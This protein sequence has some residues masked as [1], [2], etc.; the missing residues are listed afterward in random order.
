M[1]KHFLVFILSILAFV[2]SAQNNAY[3]F[4]GTTHGLSARTHSL[5]G[6]NIGVMYDFNLTKSFYLQ[7]GFSLNQ[8]ITDSNWE[9]TKMVF[10]SNIY[11]DKGTITKDNYIVI[12]ASI[13][14][15]LNLKDDVNL[16]FNV[17]ANLGIYTGGNVL[18]RSSTGTS[19]N[20]L[21]YNLDAHTTSV[22]LVMGS[23]VEINKIFLG[24]EANYILT[25]YLPDFILKT[26]FGIRF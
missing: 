12:P 6:Y 1:K 23:G 10:D 24:I 4:G 13:L 22:G 14:Y 2:I 26:K 5:P 20:M 15:N 7:T 16:K 25:D 18:F 17:G 3:V 9:T 21:L 19:N 11:F 8:F